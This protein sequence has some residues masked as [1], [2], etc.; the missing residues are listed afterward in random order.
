MNDNL[1]AC[2]C[3]GGAEQAI[4]DILLEENVLIF[5]KQQLLDEKIIR[6][7]SASNFER[8]YLRKNFAKKITLYRILDSRKENFKLSKLY[9]DKVEVINVV[10]APEIEM[11][12]IHN[13]N[14]YDDF[15]KRK[16]L[17]SVYCKQILKYHDVKSYMFIKDY[18]S[19]VD[20]LIS[21]ITLYHSKS[22]IQDGEST[23][24]DLLK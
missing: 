24:Y 9:K 21:A 2:I 20:T 16:M 8:D 23:L 22:K 18:F 5:E 7:R 11:L 15:K 10:T 1:I 6:T 12:I 19:N 3:E 17:P 4:M 13:E 14:K